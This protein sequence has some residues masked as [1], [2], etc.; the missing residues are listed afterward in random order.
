MNVTR[1]LTAA[2]FAALIAGPVAAQQTTPN[3]PV[4]AEGQPAMDAPSPTNPEMKTPM[5]TEG[6]TS[7]STNADANGVVDS[8]TATSDASP[9]SDAPTRAGG[10]P[11]LD[12]NA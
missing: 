11:R 6:A 8:P 2:A 7:T 9:P 1:L 10:R 12:A 5:T 3:Q 4:D